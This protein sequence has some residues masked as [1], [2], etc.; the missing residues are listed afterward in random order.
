MWNKSSKKVLFSDDI[1]AYLRKPRNATKNL[2]GLKRK[3][4]KMAGYKKSGF[5]FIL[6]EQDVKLEALTELQVT[7]CCE[8]D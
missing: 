1:N 5:R 6:V 8:S 4:I 7:M 2:F 3:F